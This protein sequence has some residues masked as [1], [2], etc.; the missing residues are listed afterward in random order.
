MNIYITDNT[1]T[2]DLVNIDSKSELLDEI[3]SALDI[4]VDDLDLSTV[5]FDLDDEEID[6]RFIGEDKLPNDEFFEFKEAVNNSRLDESVFLA[7]LAVGIGLD[8]IEESYRGA[9][10]DD[11]K[12]AQDFAERNDL[13]NKDSAWPYTCIDWE[14]AAKELMYDYVESN[15]YYFSNV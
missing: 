2:I 4:D 14:F 12:F 10:P 11:K 1:I 15:G 3:A 5:D 6:Q 7:G 13:I 8:D 9:Y